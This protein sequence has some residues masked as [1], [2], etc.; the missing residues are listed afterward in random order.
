[1]THQKT[2][3]CPQDSSSDARLPYLKWDS[4]SFIQLY[5]LFMSLY[6][7]CG[8]CFATVLS[9]GLNQCLLHSYVLDGGRTGRQVMA[10][11]LP[12]ALPTFFL[13]CLSP[14]DWERQ[15]SSSQ[16]FL[17][18]KSKWVP[19]GKHFCTP[20]PRSRS[21]RQAVSLMPEKPR[22]R[23]R[24]ND[25]KVGQA[26]YLVGGSPYKGNLQGDTREVTRTA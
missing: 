15:G 18:M 22:T 4:Y 8:V 13:H 19:R 9:R 14:A 17:C 24:S 12:L 3:L 10:P 23:S 11:L 6:I 1:M 20:E 25:S 7:I 26:R 5:L 21:H 2:Y 16:M